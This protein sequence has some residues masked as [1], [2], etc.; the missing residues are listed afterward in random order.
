MVGVGIREEGKA[1][2]T[3]YAPDGQ[4]C[5]QAE[6]LGTTLGNLLEKFLKDL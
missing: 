3:N 1:V 4:V 6:A 5:P 2:V